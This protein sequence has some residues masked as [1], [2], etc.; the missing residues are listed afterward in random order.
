[1]DED[2]VNKQ[3]ISAL[4]AKVQQLTQGMNESDHKM[5]SYHVSLQINIHIN[6]H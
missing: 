4:K 5:L 2:A 3:T 6:I 1:M